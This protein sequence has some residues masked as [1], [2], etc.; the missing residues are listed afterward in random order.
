MSKD[1]YY[2]SHDSNAHT[3]PKMLRLRMNLGWEGYGLFWAITECLRSQHE[4]FL[5]EEDF[6]FLTLALAIDEAKLNQVKSKFLEIGLLVLEDGKIFSPSLMKR[7][8]K[9]DKLRNIRSEAGKKGGRP[10]KKSSGEAEEPPKPSIKPKGDPSKKIFL[11]ENFELFWKMYPKRNGKKV[12]KQNAKKNFLK[13][14]VEDVD[15]ILTNTQNYGINQ[16]YAKDPE[17][18]LINDFWKDWD[19]PQTTTN[20]FAGKNK[21]SGQY[22]VGEK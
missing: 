17:R 13:M 21:S 2:F 12:G 19:T 22:A 14:K 6:S 7:M 18:F 4:Y 20:E 16:D 5:S 10:P 11:E 1:S 9:A 15:R 3:D 8:E